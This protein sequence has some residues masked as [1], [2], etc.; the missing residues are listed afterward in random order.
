MKTSPEEVSSEPHS[1]NAD[2]TTTVSKD[3]ILP[4]GSTL[5]RLKR[6][7]NE[8]ATS[9]GE[10]R[11]LIMLCEKKECTPDLKRFLASRIKEFGRLE[12]ERDGYR[13]RVKEGETFLGVVPSEP[14]RTVARYEDWSVS[15][16]PCGTQ[17]ICGFVF[18]H[19]HEPDGKG[20]RKWSHNAHEL[21][22][23]DIFW[24]GKTHTYILGNPADDKECERRRNM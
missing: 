2:T 21:R 15:T 11:D 3:S 4:C 6:K 22:C 20:F 24:E 10:T 17:Y 5:K 13:L 19:A 12:R 1:S 8:L 16:L 9:M 14:Q 23:G 7:V 18:G